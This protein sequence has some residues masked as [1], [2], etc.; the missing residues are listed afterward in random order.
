VLWGTL[1]PHVA[2]TQHFLS[3]IVAVIGTT[4]SAYLYTWQSNMEVEEEIARGRTRLSQ[5]VGASEQELG[6]ARRDVWIGIAFSNAIMFFIMLAASATLHKTGQTE[7]ETA[8]QA[9][10][11]LRP[12]AGP[13]AAWLFTLG[14]IGVG[15][16]AVPVMT[17]GAAYD[18]SQA[19][20]WR[21]SLHSAPREAKPFYG[22]VAAFTLVAMGLNFLG[23]NP[24]RALVWSG[25]VQ[26][27]STPPLLL[28]IMLMTNNRRVMGEHVNGRVL[29]VLGWL[30]TAMVFAATLGLVATW[31][32]Q[33]GG[34]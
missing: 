28:L 25:I 29:N 3:M 17:I 9:A 1:I 19:M 13:A 6:Q 31:V 10:E 30:T 14:I 20:G 33:A 5:R 15:C 23:F 21:H 11:A 7:I 34:K 4:L 26:A 2:F 22:A 24:M 27:F 16:L 18:L 8:A 32:I 12:I